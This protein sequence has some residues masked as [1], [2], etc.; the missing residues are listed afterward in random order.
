MGRA[1]WAAPVDPEGSAPT[2]GSATGTC[3]LHPICFSSPGPVHSPHTCARPYPHTGAAPRAH[4]LGACEL[5]GGPTG[6][7]SMGRAQ[8]TIPGQP[9]LTELPTAQTQNPTA[10]ILL[11]PA[12]SGAVGA[13][14]GQVPRPAAASVR[15]PPRPRQHAEAQPEQAMFEEHSDLSSLWVRGCIG[16]GRPNLPPWHGWTGAA[17]APPS[18]WRLG[19]ESQGW[20]DAQWGGRKPPEPPKG[21]L[22][23][24]LPPGKNR[25]LCVSFCPWSASQ[26]G[27]LCLTKGPQ[28]PAPRKGARKGPREEAPK[29]ARDRAGRGAVSLLHPCAGEGLPSGADAT[30]GQE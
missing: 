7:G 8:A 6:L 17:L 5:P 30:T 23:S 28:I 22:Q 25:K 24:L 15:P 29:E 1:V 9:A 26:S 2:L 3:Q 12:P 19:R 18:C 21:G 20:G 13:A 14:L 11:A 27:K 10:L 4:P 16:K